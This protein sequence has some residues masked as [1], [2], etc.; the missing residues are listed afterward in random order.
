MTAS[1]KL[2]LTITS[3]MNN[4]EIS[5]ILNSDPGI[6]KIFI[7]VFPA[8]K[9]LIPSKSGYYVANTDPHSKPGKH[10]V[11]FYVPHNEEQPVEYWDSYGFKPPSIF[12]PFL[13]TSYK[14]ST[15]FI[16]H[17]LS[18]T[19]GQYCIF[20]ILKRYNGYSMKDIVS[21][22]SEN[23]L[24]NDI[25]VNKTIEDHFCLD[26]DIFDTQYIYQQISKSLK[27]Y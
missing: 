20:Y 4:K 17:P 6:Q 14:R 18:S 7:G 2:I 16:Q 8:D 27:A 23:K 13:S 21:I 1:C 12:L 26:L 19:C 22:F 24:E 9:L 3:Y 11:A 25:I 15:K 10:W 5:I